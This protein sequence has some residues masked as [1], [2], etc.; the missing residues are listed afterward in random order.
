MFLLDVYDCAIVIS[1]DSD[2]AEAMKL[3]RVDCKKTVGL[4]TPWR[5]RAS[6]QLM[7]NYKDIPNSLITAI[8][9]ANSTRKDFIANSIIKRDPKV[10]GVYRLIM[11]N[12]SDNYRTSSI[13]GIMKRIKAKGITVIVYEPIMK[14]NNFFQSEIVKD[15][16]KFK[17]MSDIIIVNRM[18]EEISDVKD[19]IY[20][21][22]LFNS[23]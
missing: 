12:N 11:K 2:L 15:L 13:Q 6:K 1:N 5:R 8:V 21:R 22:D 14:E 18:T 4:F 9:D 10:V 23:D 17:K 3:V 7:A 19:K 16:N 20:T